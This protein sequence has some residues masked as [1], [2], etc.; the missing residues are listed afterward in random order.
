MNKY[1]ISRRNLLRRLALL[2]GLVYPKS[3]KPS[4]YQED[5]C[6]DELNNLYL[7]LLKREMSEKASLFKRIINNYGIEVLAI[8]RE[9]TI[10]QAAEKLLSVEITDRNLDAIMD[11][12]WGHTELT[13]EYNIENHTDGLLKLRITRCL[14]AE[15]M[16]KLNASE[17]GDAFYCAYD[18]GY[19]MGLNSKIKF[20]R[21]KTL[22]L[23][24]DYCD[25]TY[26]LAFI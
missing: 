18:Y 19:C 15:E 1:Y 13:H 12:L 3:L 24:H 26:E 5:L 14:F 8:I 9:N 10:S 4:G 25:H 17:I 6:E 7:R 20:T 11:N 2:A 21:S 22:M 23:G 16:R